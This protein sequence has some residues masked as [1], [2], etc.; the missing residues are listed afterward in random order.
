MS[1]E[2]VALIVS[3][4][5]DYSDNFLNYGNYGDALLNP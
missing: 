2:S 3:A 1:R 4:T 5:V